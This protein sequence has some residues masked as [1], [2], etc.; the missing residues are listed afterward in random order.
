MR[1]PEARVP[2]VSPVAEALGTKR[3]FDVEHWRCG[4]EKFSAGNQN[5]INMHGPPPVLHPQVC[6]LPPQATRPEAQQ[7]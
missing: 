5:A 6:Q 3:Q 2:N 7:P 1:G 4:T